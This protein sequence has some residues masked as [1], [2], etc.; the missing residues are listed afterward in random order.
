MLMYRPCIQQHGYNSVSQ[1]NMFHCGSFATLADLK[2]V[3][4]PFENSHRPDSFIHTIVYDSTFAF[5]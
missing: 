3:K 2:D 5:C 1:I 4:T